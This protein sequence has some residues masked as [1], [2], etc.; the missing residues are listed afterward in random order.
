[1]GSTNYNDGN[2]RRGRNSNIRET[3]KFVSRNPE[4]WIW[5]S[6]E[7]HTH[8]PT[9]NTYKTK[10]RKKLFS[11]TAGNTG[12]WSSSEGWT[13]GELHICPLLCLRTLS[14]LRYEGVGSPQRATV[15][16]QGEG[17]AGIWVYRGSWDS[18]KRGPRRRAL[19]RERTPEISRSVIW[20]LF[21]QTRSYAC[22]KKDSGVPDR[23]QVVGGRAGRGW[24]QN[25]GSESDKYWE[26]LELWQPEWRDLV[27]NSASQVKPQK[28]HALRIEL[29]CFPG[30]DY[31]SLLLKRLKP[32]F[33][34]IEPIC[35]NIL[36]S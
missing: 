32:S 28:Y 31:S 22:T 2:K 1:M 13:W 14:K 4:F 5:Q 17:S 7:N 35:H 33:S 34:R 20:T 25:R 24:Q 21:S 12:L 27:N 30:A 36:P 15:G 9:A 16:L 18:C 23:E 6:N 11:C 26:R 3:K 10:H 19:C 8:L 29:L